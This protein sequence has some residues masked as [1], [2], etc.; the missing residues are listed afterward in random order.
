VER[1]MAKH[2]LISL[3]GLIFMM[4]CAAK[5]FSYLGSSSARNIQ[6]TPVENSNCCQS[7][8]SSVNRKPFFAFEKTHDEFDTTSRNWHREYEKNNSYAESW[9]F[10]VQTQQETV[11]FVTLSVTNLG[12]RTFDAVCDVRFYASNGDQ[13]GTYAQYRR[14]DVSGARNKLDLTIGP[15]QLVHMDRTYRLSIAENDL[16]LDLTLENVLPEFQFGN[17]RV[18]FYEDRSAE[19]NIR[20]DA[21]R[22]VAKGILT[23]ADK[24]FSLDG[25]GYHDHVWSSIKLPTF[26]KKWYTLRLYDE[27]F[28]IILHQ[29]HLADTF[30]GGKICAGIIGDN[31]RLI[32]FRTYCYN[33]LKWRKDATSGLQIPEELALSIRTKEYTVEGTVKEVRFLESVEVLSRLS[34]SIRTAVK[35]FYSKPY[36]IRYQAQC[37]INLIDNSGVRYPI[38]GLGVV[39][40]NYY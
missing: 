13:Y 35:V 8:I 3:V 22:A 32:P 39:G 20:F 27:R 25:D 21:P 33:P 4:V 31:N 36:L 40:A 30:G 28:T 19:W 11:L 7:S 12:I 29:I 26:A 37:D 5:L 15:N 10:L 18:L 24:T 1:L 2:A 14:K 9:F 17:G 16:Q 34:W 6:H 38:S 23:V